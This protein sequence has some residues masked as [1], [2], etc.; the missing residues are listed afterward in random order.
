V[1]AVPR[2]GSLSPALLLAALT[3]LLSLGGCPSREQSSGKGPVDGQVLFLATC[4]KCHGEA[5]HADTPQGQLVGA[6]DL[7]REEARRMSDAEIRHQIVA[8]K[9]RMPAFGPVLSDA[10]IDALVGEVRKRQR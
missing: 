3:F 1:A 8:G 5:G 9:G 6:K 10:E 7:T 4:A 2:S